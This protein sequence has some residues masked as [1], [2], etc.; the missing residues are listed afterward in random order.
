MAD[1]REFVLVRF[2]GTKKQ[3]RLSFNVKSST[4]LLSG[5]LAGNRTRDCAVRGRRLNRLTT[6]PF[7]Y[8]LSNYIIYVK[9]L[10]AI[11]IDLYIIFV[12]NIIVGLEL[13]H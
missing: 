1:R 5:D 10:Q 2:Y 9:A 12:Y 13:W 4:L 8:L 11:L 3:S 7:A 6:R